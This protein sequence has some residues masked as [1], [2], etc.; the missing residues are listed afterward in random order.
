MPFITEK[1]WDRIGEAVGGRDAMLIVTAW[2]QLSGLE[3]K[4]ADE[5]MGWV[6]GVIE[7]IRSVRSEM[8]VPPA[9]KLPLVVVG[10]SKSVRERAERHVDTISR[11]ARLDKLDFAKAAPKGALQIVTREA[12]LALPIA[13]IIDVDAESE[14]LKREISKMHGEIEKLDQKLSDEKFTAR[15]PEHVVE[16]N[17]ERRSQAA[18]AATRLQEALKRLE[19]TH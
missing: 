8:N 10:A 2:P 4:T 13:D 7:E 18:A 6:I 5:E 12:V 1:L 9:A 15:A 3:D 19:A 17:R 11:L 16:E 14:R